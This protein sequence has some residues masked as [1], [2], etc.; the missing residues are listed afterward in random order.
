SR[1]DASAVNPVA[2]LISREKSMR[3]F[4]ATRRGRGI[5]AALGVAASAALLVGCAG[6]S[7]PAPDESSSEAP[8][9]TLQVAY[10]SFAVANTYDEPMLAAAQAVA[11]ENNIEVTVFD[12][13]L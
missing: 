10:M 4:T 11:A 13:N 12:S 3:H 5:A 8:Q 7:A 1:D 6:G 9:E 2:P